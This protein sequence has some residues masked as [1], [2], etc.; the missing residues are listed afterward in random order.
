M[1]DFKTVR[2]RA[3]H[4]M[5]ELGEQVHLVDVRTPAEYRAGHPAPALSIPLDRLTPK[6]LARR[7]GDGA[8]GHQTPLFLSCQSGIR[9]EQAAERLMH[10]GLENLYLVDGGADAWSRAGLPMQRCGQAISLERQVQI[11]IGALLLLKVVFGFT[12]H[13]LFFALIPLIGAGL[14][15]AGLTRWCAMARLIANMPWNQRSDCAKQAAV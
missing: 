5:I 10:A 6:E 13:E 12:F 9:A 7:L 2:P 1:K 8:V 11:S 3:L 14:I 4:D 15:V